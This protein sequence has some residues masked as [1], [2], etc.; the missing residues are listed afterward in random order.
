MLFVIP[1][2]AGIQQAATHKKYLR[3]FFLLKINELLRLN[4][5]MHLVGMD[6]RLRGDDTKAWFLLSIFPGH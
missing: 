6:P 2:K 1:A 3:C 4:E 5:I